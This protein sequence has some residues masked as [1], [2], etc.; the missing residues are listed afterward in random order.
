M[1]DKKPPIRVLALSSFSIFNLMNSPKISNFV[2]KDP[3]PAKTIKIK[4]FYKSKF[5]SVFCPLLFHTISS[6][7]KN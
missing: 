3:I 4:Y 1:T 2:T 7:S 6:E 5:N